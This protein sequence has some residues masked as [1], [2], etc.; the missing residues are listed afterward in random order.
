MRRVELL[1][2]SSIPSTNLA[3]TS[4]IYK[5]KLILVIVSYT[6]TILMRS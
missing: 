4:L 1:L 5:N 6:Y 3:R 2:M